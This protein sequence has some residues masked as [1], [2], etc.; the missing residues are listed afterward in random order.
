MQPCT[1]DPRHWGDF[2]RVPCS[3]SPPGRSSITFW[4]C[5]KGDKACRPF[6]IRA[7]GS[8]HPTAEMSTSVDVIQTR[9]WWKSLLSTTPD[10][11]K[12]PFTTGTG[13]LCPQPTTIYFTLLTRWGSTSRRFSAVY[14]CVV[15]LLTFH[16][17]SCMHGSWFQS[18]RN[19]FNS[20]PLSAGTGAWG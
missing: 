13:S 3:P 2:Q 9:L 16:H 7:L 19:T 17:T 12:R 8:L 15:T 20:S 5:S 14:Y 4:H 11:L 6:R 1:L 10:N 18:W